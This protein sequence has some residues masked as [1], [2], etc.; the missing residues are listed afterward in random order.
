MLVDAIFEPTTTMSVRNKLQC[1]YV[2]VR[3]GQMDANCVSGFW[4][5]LR[6]CIP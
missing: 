2:C 5:L 3:I 6:T 1:V 4:T